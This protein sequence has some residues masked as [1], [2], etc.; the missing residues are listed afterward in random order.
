M[1]GLDADLVDGNLPAVGAALHIGNVVAVVV[2]ELSGFHLGYPNDTCTVPDKSGS[3]SL[4]ATVSCAYPPKGVVFM[5]PAGL[6]RGW[7]PQIPE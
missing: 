2:C 7:R 5:L 3:K 4:T 1:P 6:E